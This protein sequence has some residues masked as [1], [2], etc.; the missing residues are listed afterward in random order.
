VDL[1]LDTLKQEILGYLGQGGFIVFRSTP[2]GLDG[3]PMVVWDSERYP[4]Y[5]MFLDTARQAG[6]KMVLFASREFEESEVEEAL[7]ELEV[8]EL[9]REERRDL[10][11]RLR[12]ARGYVGI[13]CSLELAFDFESRLFVYE[14]RPDWY[15]D[16]LNACDEIAAEGPEDSEEDGDLGGYFSRN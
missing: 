8:C 1:N 2:G 15:E 12:Q 3:L 16:F 4:D 14:L 6:S 7:E 10:E 13:T 5:Q 9:S 11:Q